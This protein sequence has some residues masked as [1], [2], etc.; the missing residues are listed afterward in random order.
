MLSGAFVSAI[1]FLAA[2]L[3]L[4][5]QKFIPLTI[6]STIIQILFAFSCGALLG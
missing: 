2:F 4:I 6:Y 3:L 1:G 5:L